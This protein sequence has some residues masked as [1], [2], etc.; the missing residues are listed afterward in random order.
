MM[1]LMKKRAL[2]AMSGGVDSSVAAAL[3]QR[4]DLDCTGVMMRLFAD[5]TLGIEEGSEYVHEMES[6]CC[7]LADAAYARQVAGQLDIPFYVFDLSEDFRRCVIDRF[8]AA[9]ARGETPNPCIDCNRYLKFEQLMARAASL[10]FDVM[11]T[12][13]YARV[14]WD[15]VAGRW[16]L[17]AARDESKD[18]SY[19]LYTLTQAQLARLRLP[20]GDLLKSEVRALAAQFGFRNA[21]KPDSQNICFVPDGDYSRF[22]ETCV[23]HDF[24]PGDFLDLSGQVMGRHQGIIRYTLGQR[25]GLGAFGRPVYVSAIDAQTNTVTLG[26]E[27]SLYGRECILR[28]LNWIAGVPETGMQSVEVKIG[29]RCARQP[30]LVELTDEGRLR[31]CFDQA[32]RAITPGQAAV[33]YQDEYVLGGG[34]IDCQ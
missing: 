21:D 14:E 22:I 34:T 4:E 1:T 12:G 27:D 9:Y 10:D 6:G 28:E 2:I 11:A 7:S 31:V 24:E 29:Y 16:L 19:V 3:L 17:R 25:K 8:V 20:L 15:E 13:H 33:L 30:A 18:Q 23:G 32:Q 5:E 26:D